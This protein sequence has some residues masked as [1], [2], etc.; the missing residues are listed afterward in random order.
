MIGSNFMKI[1]ST[2]NLGDDEVFPFSS[3]GTWEYDCNNN[4]S[5]IYFP[6]PNNQLSEYWVK[7]FITNH[8]SNH[9]NKRYQDF[10]FFPG[11]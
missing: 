4:Q 2:L 8:I 10:L 5:N 7:F 6:T 9:F 1:S 11:L 3:F